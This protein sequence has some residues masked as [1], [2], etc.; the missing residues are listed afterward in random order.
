MESDEWEPAGIRELEDG[1]WDA[2]RDEGCTA[3]IAGPGAGKTEFLAQRGAYLLETGRCKAP[4]RILAISYKRDAAANLARRVRVRVPVHA[5]RFDSYTFDAFTK[6]LLDR[7]QSALPEAWRMKSGYTVKFWKGY[8]QRNTLRRLASQ[9]PAAL[10]RKY[11]ELPTDSFIDDV[12]GSWDLPLDPSR[13][14]TTANEFAAWAWWNE[15]YLS[16]NRPQVDFVMINRLAELVVRANPHVAR[17]LRRTYPFVFMDE[18]QDTTAA[19]LS[20]L[21]R[22]F[23][24][25]AVVTAVGDRKQRIMGFAGALEDSFDTYSQAFSANQYSLTWNFRSSNGLVALQHVIASRLDVDVIATVSKAEVEEGHTAAQ[26]WS[27]GTESREANH[28]AEWIAGDMARSGRIGSDFALVVRQKTADYVKRLKPAF[29]AHGI[30]L[31]N[32]DTKYGIISLQDL[33]KHEV[34]KLVLGM[35]KL[36][37]EPRGRA[38]EW[39]E[40]NSI[41]DSIRGASGGEAT[42]R[43]QSD[44]LA[45]FTTELRGWLLANPIGGTKAQDVIACAADFISVEELTGYVA[46]QHR[47]EN[48]MDV[49][50]ALAGRLEDVLPNANSWEQA[51]HDFE[52]V[53]AV[54]LLTVHKS[55]GLEYHTVFFLGLDD[56]QWWSFPSNE[57]EGTAT[58]FVGLSRAA[59]RLVFTCTQAGAR[60]GDIAELYAM[61]DLA[62]VEETRFDHE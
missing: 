49:L 4:Q 9:V 20:F 18:F 38:R 11:S 14:P 35:L 46:G 39:Q 8:E 60:D 32:D 47:G 48:V 44:S 15:N 51:L 24:G 62:G 21:T 5:A 56:K 12:V 30:Q 26:L 28:L 59:Q 43:A 23:R 41:L 52:A 37:L 33:L 7:F 6:G 2:L 50:L 29:R 16:S 17:A 57:D 3:V 61:L 19:Q 13:A 25:T 36:A 10:R 58:F 40:V 42:S 22:V 55:K 27:Y 54:S 34:T 53:E 45:S 31:R 1:A